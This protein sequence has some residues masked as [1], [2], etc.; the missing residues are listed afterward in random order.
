MKIEAPKR[1]ISTAFSILLKIVLIWICT[2]FSI[3]CD[4][5]PI[6]RDDQPFV[7]C[8]SSHKLLKFVKEQIRI[9]SF[10]SS[11]VILTPFLMER[12]IESCNI[13]DRDLECIFNS[14]TVVNGFWKILKS[15]ADLEHSESQGQHQISKKVTK[16]CGQ[17]ELRKIICEA[18]TC[19]DKFEVLKIITYCEVLTNEMEFIFECLIVQNTAE[20]NSRDKV[21]EWI[22]N[23][24]YETT[25]N[26][27]KLES[28]FKQWSKIIC[29]KTD[30][31]SCVPKTIWSQ[32]TLGSPDKIFRSKT[33][34]GNG[35]SVDRKTFERRF[36][37]LEA[38]IYKKINVPIKLGE[39]LILICLNYIFERT[40]SNNLSELEKVLY[41]N[42]FWK[43][44]A[45]LPFHVIRKIREKEL[46]K[47]LETTMLGMMKILKFCELLLTKDR[48]SRSKFDETL[49]LIKS[50]QGIYCKTNLDSYNSK[51]WIHIGSRTQ[52]ELAKYGN[53][54]MDILWKAL[55][56]ILYGLYEIT[57][58]NSTIMNANKE[59]NS[60]LVKSDEISFPK[61]SSWKLSIKW[62]DKGIRVFSSIDLDNYKI[63]YTSD[64]ITFQ[65]VDRPL[66]QEPIYS[67]ELKYFSVHN[68]SKITSGIK[69]FLPVAEYCEVYS[70]GSKD[71]NSIATVLEKKDGAQFDEIVI[72][73]CDSGLS[74]GDRIN[75]ISQ[76]M[77]QISE[78]LDIDCVKPGHIISIII[79]A[80]CDVS[81]LIFFRWIE[82]INHCTLHVFC[83]CG[84]GKACFFRDQC[85]ARQ[86]KG[87]PIIFQHQN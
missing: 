68:C 3:R 18:R 9:K 22:V 12:R 23:K 52:A 17:V 11:Q 61:Y 54:F 29:W 62:S 53:D 58:I 48:D 28:Q 2:V 44:T 8:A 78:C 76:T 10:T 84:R 71:L 27:E 77:I 55:G 38:D 7:C 81:L 15:T 21:L 47:K 1:M 26:L 72:K 79:Y 13:R 20:L 56:N 35:I 19:E 39:R 87:E 5:I 46:G 41:C 64:G 43:L 25:L 42:L 66:C 75:E 74:E 32:T 80:R 83:S 14:K 37:S 67:V 82:K 70:F 33:L 36:S 50:G 85:K 6:Y 45:S 65:S 86:R 49:N 73:L 34:F 51:S 16:S 69:Q 31:Y 40:Q 63:G 59:E 60:E 57:T 4:F 30:Y 24:L